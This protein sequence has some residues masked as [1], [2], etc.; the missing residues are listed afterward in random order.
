MIL[1]T[2]NFFNHLIFFPGD[3]L[4][5]DRTK[6]IIAMI[7]LAIF[8]GGVAFAV[9]AIRRAIMINSKELTESGKR[10]DKLGREIL[11]PEA[12]IELNKI[13][14]H[15]VVGGRHTWPNKRRATVEE[16]TALKKAESRDDYLKIMP[17][18]NGGDT[19]F[20][21]TPEEYADGV[22][23]SLNPVGM[24]VYVDQKLRWIIYW[25]DADS[26]QKYK[27]IEALVNEYNVK[28]KLIDLSDALIHPQNAVLWMLV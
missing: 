3:G 25:D 2:E 27:E 4:P 18:Y 13:R 17:G 19:P 8:T 22:N 26:D 23:L 21:I 12:T 15:T 1:T 24:K 16:L 20:R 7:A 5:D 11:S 9:C 28:G 6:T 10:I 14:Y